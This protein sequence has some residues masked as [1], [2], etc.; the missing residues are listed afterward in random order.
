MSN[1]P[2]FF[3]GRK[4]SPV[5]PT[6]RDVTV[7][8]VHD[9]IDEYADWACEQG[10]YLPPGYEKDPSGWAEVLRK[11]QKAFQ[12]L[13]E[14]ASGDLDD[15]KIEE[16]KDQIQEGLELFGKHLFYLT[17]TIVDRGPAH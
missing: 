3:K 17:D 11:M 4:K 1:L 13:S 2:P 7:R 12:L 6:V 8:S 15:A 10:L 9:A 14:H 16:L 5:A